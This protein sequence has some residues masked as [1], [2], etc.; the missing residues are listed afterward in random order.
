MKIKAH[1]TAAAWITASVVMTSSWS[2]SV[3]A[4]PSS[5]PKADRDGTENPESQTA[6]Y[7]DGT[8][9]ATGQYGNAPSFITVTVKLSAG[10]I[11]SAKVITRATNPISLYYQQRFASAAP[12]VV[13]GRPIEQVT[14]GR[15]AGSSGTPMG[16]NAAIAQIKQQAASRARTTADP[17]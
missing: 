16:F 10:H 6:T 15:L 2:Q 14:L 5:S 3:A 12:E 13:V 1:F 11:V 7:A 17:Q 4:L 8:Y 9:T